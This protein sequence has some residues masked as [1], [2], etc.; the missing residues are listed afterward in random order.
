MLIASRAGPR[1]RHLRVQLRSYSGAMAWL[2][3]RLWRSFRWRLVRAIA[4]AQVGVVVV[5]AGASLAVYYAQKL[6]SDGQL[7]LGR[8]ALE[9]RA[10]TTLMLIVAVVLVVL[11][12]GGG[13]LLLA[14][15]SIVDMAAELNHH[16]RMD[17]AMAYGGELPE[18]TSWRTDRALWRALWVLQTRDARRTAIVTRNLLRN[19]VHVGIGVV[20]FGA[21]FY[22]EPF[23]TV[24]FVG[25][26]LVALLAYYAANIVSVRATRRYE[27]VAPG[28]R[29]GLHQ[30]VQRAQTLSQPWLT[31]AELEP[32]LGN[33]T[34]DEETRAFRDRFGAHIYTEF[35]SFAVMGV[36]LAGFIGYMGSEA[37]AGAMPWT[38]LIAYMVVLRVT[39]SSLRQ[40][41]ATV[42]FFSRFY[43]SIERLHRFFCASNNRRSPEPLE[44]LPVHPSA[45]TLTES[46][47]MARP[48]R[49]GDV[50]GLTLPVSLSR[51]SL[52]LM[53]PVF[54]GSD[55][56]ARRRRLGQIAMAAPLAVP[57]VAASMHSLLP[58]DGDWDAAGLRARL[59][60]HADAVEAAIGLDPHAAVPADGWA[61]LPRE[62]AERLV[63]VA[64]EASERP[65]LAVDAGLVTPEWVE[66]LS[67]EGEGRILLVCGTSARRVEAGLGVT[68]ELVV[69]PAGQVVAIGSPAW[70]QQRWDAISQ[71]S[72]D[73]E[74][75]EPDSDE[76]LDEE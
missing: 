57:P 54:A 63:L 67:Q 10:D 21:L 45:A 42:A 30:L 64:A 46:P 1:V 7:Q 5:G 19:T 73:G 74:A 2:L 28:A 55:P 31:R 40:V 47:E 12:L 65:V 16:V 41:L 75:V 17:V 62:A 49:R 37:L 25:V 59:G 4:T 53:V 68:R 26:V 51:Y 3:G 61:Q 32:A 14:Q 69:S 35:L 50:M 20:G 29:K 22:L 13:V 39:L 36:V 23:V 44:E 8:V 43:P 71:H 70:I 56:K 72:P 34:V 27:T 76:E 9:A 38:R 66:R 48:A 58:L 18:S 15:R 60:E 52:G 24:L 6:E 11:L 33:E